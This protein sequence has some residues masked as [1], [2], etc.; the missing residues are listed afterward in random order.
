M[1]AYRVVLAT[2]GRTA[3]G[4]TTLAKF[5]TSSLGL[6]YVPEAAFKRALRSDYSTKDSLDEDLRDIA[7]Q[8]S[9]AA[10]A[11]IVAKG[12]TPIIDASFHQ[13]RRRRWLIQMARDGKAGLVFLY[14][15]CDDEDETRRRIMRRRHELKSY[16]T[17]ADSMSIYAHINS[18]FQ[19]LDETEL[20]RSEPWAVLT[21]NTVENSVRH[22][23]ICSSRSRLFEECIEVVHAAVSE[24]LCAQRKRA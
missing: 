3:S 11:G 23:A 15:R 14:C 1:E 6:Y 18:G 16:S 10:A 13:R 17:H 24:Y 7:Y 8:A 19:E 22:I 12:Q 9:I 21:A 5:L 2:L 4:K 20:H